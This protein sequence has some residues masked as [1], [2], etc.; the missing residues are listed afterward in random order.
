MQRYPTVT[1]ACL[2]ATQLLA[3]WT[4]YGARQGTC[5]LIHSAVGCIT[6]SKWALMAQ[7]R[8]VLSVTAPMG[9]PGFGTKQRKHKNGS[10]RLWIVHSLEHF[11]QF[12]ASHR[13]GGSILHSVIAMY[14]R[15][16][17]QNRKACICARIRMRMF[18]K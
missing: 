12:G 7:S 16:T 10:W 8:S 15:L 14:R 4:R 6:F 9:S 18:Q 11:A 3:L 5:R 2:L 1:N 13:G 17:R